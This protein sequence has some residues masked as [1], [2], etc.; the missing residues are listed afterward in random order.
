MGQFNS[1]TFMDV[2][3]GASSLFPSGY[4]N[5]LKRDRDGNGP[6]STLLGKAARNTNMSDGINRNLMQ[7]QP[8]L[9]I[10]VTRYII[11]LKFPSQLGNAG[12]VHATKTFVSGDVMFALRY[13]EALYQAGI[14]SSITR[15][16]PP[17][18]MSGVNLPTLNYVLMNYQM[19]V[20]YYILGSRDRQTDMFKKSLLQW[21][22]YFNGL[23]CGLNFKNQYMEE[24][25]LKKLKEKVENEKGNFL[26]INMLMQEHVWQFMRNFVK[27]AGVFIGSE[28]QGGQHQGDSNPASHNPIDF[29]AA[30]QVSGK[31][32][33]IRN[34]WTTSRQ[35]V[36]NGDTLGFTLECIDPKIHESDVKL[37]LSGNAATYTPITM[38][39]CDL[40]T[41]IDNDKEIFHRDDKLEK[42]DD[43]EPEKNKAQKTGPVRIW[44]LTPAIHNR[45][46]H[47]VGLV[48]E[49]LHNLQ[50]NMDVED[51]YTNFKKSLSSLA[52][53]FYGAYFM[54]FGIVNQ[55]SK[56]VAGSMRAMDYACIATA[57]T[58]PTNSEVLLRF[59]T[60]AASADDEQEF[61]EILQK[62]FNVAS[63][64]SVQMLQGGGVFAAAN[65]GTKE[66]DVSS[67]ATADDNG[68]NSLEGGGWGVDPSLHSIP[69]AA[70]VNRGL[71]ALAAK[72]Q[73]AKEK[74]QNR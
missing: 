64:A 58:V 26:T 30:M 28:N 74:R 51:D 35:D 16:P 60:A 72:S 32:E 7:T 38:N 54:Q 27:V 55:M 25:V 33:K 37:N 43:E 15:K 42:G 3:K 4:F 71:H 61:E 19:F 13:T 53:N 40:N 50:D 66:T 67:R 52:R 62:Q 21:K 1:R 14:A 44:L 73:R 63:D 34:L 9:R 70:E 59:T 56:G 10:N 18:H 65:E 39:F 8:G 45:L 46:K 31:F 17:L 48:H 57:C 24:D 12:E 5:E 29:M 49:G 6:T 20:W 22:N 47:S 2:G 11:P 23:Y 36:S 68:D 41:R 69:I